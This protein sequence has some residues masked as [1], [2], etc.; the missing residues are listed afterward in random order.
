MVH[1]DEESWLE[2]KIN[3]NAQRLKYQMS[4]KKLY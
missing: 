3:N 2:G 4:R 1:V